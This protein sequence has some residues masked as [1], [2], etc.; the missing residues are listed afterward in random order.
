MAKY[1]EGGEGENNGRRKNC[2]RSSSAGYSK[3]ALDV[4]S[5]LHPVLNLPLSNMAEPYKQPENSSASYSS[6]KSVATQYI[7]NP[8]TVRSG[9]SCNS[10]CGGRYL[11]C[12]GSRNSACSNPRI[13]SCNLRNSGYKNRTLAPMLGILLL[14]VMVSDHC[15]AQ[16]LDDMPL[17]RSHTWQ[18]PGCHRIGK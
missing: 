13:L 12:K 3:Y 16:L 2:F 4:N 7:F 11:A 17:V 18:T 9:N 5:T 1:Y 10:S 6:E 14:L 8:K 15:N